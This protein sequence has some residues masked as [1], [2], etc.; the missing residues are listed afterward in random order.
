MSEVVIKLGENLKTGEDFALILNKS[1]VHVLLR[2]ISGKGKTTALKTIIKNTPSD[3]KFIIRDCKQ[4][5]FPESLK[6]KFPNIQQIS[7]RDKVSTL[8]FLCE[9]RNYLMELNS[10][11]E[12]QATIVIWDEFQ[13]D[14]DILDN[15]SFE[16]AK[17]HLNCIHKLSRNANYH[18]IFSSQDGGR[19]NNLL[20]SMCSTTIYLG[21]LPEEYRAVTELFGNAGIAQVYPY[22]DY[23]PTPVRIEPTLKL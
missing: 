9:I 5:D 10:I 6:D 23:I 12:G 14:L 15:I 20:A 1:N 16:I 21:K 8:E 11:Q 2:A 19:Y 7:K 4:V 17:D 13:V 22:P 18:F 3:V